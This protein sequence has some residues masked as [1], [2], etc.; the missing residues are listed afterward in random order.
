MTELWRLIA[1]I[2]VM[3][4]FACGLY[5]H[6]GYLPVLPTVLKRAGF[7]FGAVLV[8]VAVSVFTNYLSTTPPTPGVKVFATGSAVAALYVFALCVQAARGRH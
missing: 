1:V 8:L 5:L 6:V 2:D 7:G 3:V 4:L